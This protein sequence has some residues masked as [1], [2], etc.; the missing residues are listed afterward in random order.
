M[1]VAIDTMGDHLIAEDAGRKLFY[2]EPT[3]RGTK[4]TMREHLKRND[5]RRTGDRLI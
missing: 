4:L 1:V 3:G 2:I 5:K